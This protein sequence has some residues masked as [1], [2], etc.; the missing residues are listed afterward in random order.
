MRP[1]KASPPPPPSHAAS[2]AERR[3]SRR[4]FD[5]TAEIVEFDEEREEE[6][7]I[8][9]LQQRSSEDDASESA[10]IQFV[11]DD[12]LHTQHHRDVDTIRRRR[13]LL[14]PAE[15]KSDGDASADASHEART[16]RV[17]EELEARQRSDM[18]DEASLA[19]GVSRL[20]SLHEAEDQWSGSRQVGANATREHGPLLQPAHFSDLLPN[21]R[22]Y[23]TP[24]ASP[25]VLCALADHD[26]TASM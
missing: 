15:K 24:F 14:Y 10:T 8:Y 11:T 7:V 1:P 17:V 26:T 5:D 13:R 21:E 22:L 16:T 6:E 18:A 23:D 2:G 9:A 19:S 12:R 25:L 4:A 20:T 3:Y